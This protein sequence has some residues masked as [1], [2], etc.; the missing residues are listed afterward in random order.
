MGCACG[1]VCRQALHAGQRGCAL[2]G[3]AGEPLYYI[4][5]G[6]GSSGNS[7]YIGTTRG[8]VIVD[9]G[10]RPDVI[11]DTLAANGVGMDRVKGVCLTHDHSDHVRYVYRLLRSHRHLRLYCTNRVLMEYRSVSRTTTSLCS[12]SFRLNLETSR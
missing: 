2:C 3:Y 10:V 6:S 8:G 4:S 5:F 11:E 1:F 9:C 12:R 7:C